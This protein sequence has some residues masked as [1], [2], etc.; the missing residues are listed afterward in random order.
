MKH[1]FFLSASSITSQSI[2]L[3]LLFGGVSL[4]LIMAVLFGAVGLP[5]ESV[6]AVLSGHGEHSAEIII[7]NLRVPRALTAILVGIH[8]SLAGAILQA[9][10]RNPLA[11][12]S[13]LGVSQGAVLAVVV[14]LLFTVFIG[15]SDGSQLFTLPV[16]YLSLVGTIGGLFTGLLVY[17]LTLRHRLSPLRLTLMGIAVGATLQAIAI[18]IVAGWG[19]TRVE[20]L[21]L[22][23]SGS[24]YARGWTHFF[25]LLPWTILGVVLMPLLQ[26]PYFLLQMEDSAA[27]SFGLSVIRY[28]TLAFAIASGLAASAVGVVGPVGFI[29]LVVPHIARSL[30]GRDSRSYFIMTALL[31]A[32]FVLGADLLGRLLFAPEEIPVGLV[33]SVL[34]AP[35]FLYLLRRNG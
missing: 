22:W 27:T 1:T 18:G 5:V 21:L 9:V 33:S 35:L 6:V 8:F 34:G 17:A 4:L 15:N 10:T 11:D 2:R 30:V 7:S 3:P 23:I 13:I 31:G 24:L 14:F 32:A 28:R 26:R 19:S 12:P 20:S 25:Y 16:Q 29:G